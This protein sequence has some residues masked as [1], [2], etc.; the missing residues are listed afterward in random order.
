MK[1]IVWTNYGSPDVLQLREVEKPAPK[2]NEVL[3]K[4]HATT[5]LIGDCYLRNLKFPIWY[6]LPIRLLVGFVKPQRR[7]ILGQELAG[8]IEAVGKN[9]TRFKKGDQVFAPT[10]LHL[11]TYAEFECLPETYLILKPAR[12][13]YEEA[14]TI[15]TGGIYGLHLLRLATVQ[16]GEK[17]LIIGAGGSIG[18]YAVQIAKTFG[19]EVTAV[20]STGKM[21]LLR[22]IGADYVIDYTRENYTNRGETYDAIIDVV[23][24]SSFSGSMRSLKPNGRYILGNPGALQR[25]RGQWASMTGGKKVINETAS[26]RAE[27]Y[28]LLTE[29][30]EA[31]KI[32]PVI[33][34]RF[35]LEQ[36]ADA[37]RY[38]DTG[39]KKGSVVIS[40]EQDH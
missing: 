10:F 26:N 24:K 4:I 28:A 39:Q 13:S 33:D 34:K 17:I 31:G 40:V 9:V 3:V 18:T 38:V 15:P 19:A 27:D 11:G 1:A 25:I 8:E 29:L 6:A 2:D 36:M 14:A 16:A 23:G 21:D 35:P 22:S 12:I 37:H 7:T 32:K 20:D 5:V 30:I